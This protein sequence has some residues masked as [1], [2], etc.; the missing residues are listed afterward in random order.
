M[1]AALK[2]FVVVIMS[3]V[4][5]ILLISCSGQSSVSPDE[6]SIPQLVQKESTTTVSA[7]VGAEIEDAVDNNSALPDDIRE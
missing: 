2:K 6:A 5:A 4:L 7:R 1:F 3:F